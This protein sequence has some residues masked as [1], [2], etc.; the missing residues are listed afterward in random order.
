MPKAP[1]AWTKPGLELEIGIGDFEHLAA[2]FA[3]R[4]GS[5]SLG[6]VGFPG[7]ARCPPKKAGESSIP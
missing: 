3:L 4:E 7:W 2:P 1:F 5:R 6:S